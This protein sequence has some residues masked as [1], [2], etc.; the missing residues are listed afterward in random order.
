MT[1]KEPARSKREKRNS[2]SVRKS[3]KAMFFHLLLGELK[4]LVAALRSQKRGRLKGNPEEAG[5]TGSID[6]NGMKKIDSLQLFCRFMV[7]LINNSVPSVSSEPT[8]GLSL[9]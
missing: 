8:K 4:R 3:S 1:I 7:Q 2:P 9:R 5:I 6:R